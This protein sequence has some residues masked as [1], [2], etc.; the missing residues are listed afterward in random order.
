[1]DDR[2]TA[3]DLPEI[4]WDAQGIETELGW[5][6][7]LVLQEYIRLGSVAVADVPGGPRG[8]QV[9]VA[10]TTEEA[11]SQ[12]LLAN[13]L[14]IDKT[15]MT[16]VIDALEAGGFVER[17]PDP[18]DRRVRQVHPTRAGRALLARTRRAL[19]AAEGV[20][21]RHLDADE[22]T[23]M[24]RLLARVALAAGAA[25]PGAPG[26]DPAFEHPLAVPE[27]SRRRT[28]TTTPS[29]SSTTPQ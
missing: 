8:Y 29:T 24:R 20:L 26:D 16:Y 10:T 4:D 21:M 5:A 7:P 3:G 27:R 9:L 14:G 15:Q 11:S 2:A 23:T 19:R 13:R 12:L 17:R 18:T 6:V 1:M 22:Q 28:Q 25:T